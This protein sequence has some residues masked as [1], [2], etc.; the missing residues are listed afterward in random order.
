MSYK[1]NFARSRLKRSCS[2]L[3]QKRFSGC[4]SKNAWVIV[5]STVGCKSF[6]ANHL[7]SSCPVSTALWL[8]LG[9][10][11]QHRGFGTTPASCSVSAAFRLELGSGSQHGGSGTLPASTCPPL[12]QS[13]RP[14]GSISA[15]DH[16]TE[17]LQRHWLL[18]LVVGFAG[19]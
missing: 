9:S 7:R 6:V 2:E 4:S 10:G 12:V 1:K 15:L 14:C 5:L 13:A 17:A 8:E 11:S 3:I 16:S 18:A 19:S